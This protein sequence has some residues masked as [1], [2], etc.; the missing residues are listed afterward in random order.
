MDYI[1]GNRKEKEILKTRGD[2][3]TDLS[4]WFEITQNDAYEQI[5]DR[6]Y[7]KRKLESEIDDSGKYCV[8]YEITN[9]FR[10]V[11]KT[12]Y[13]FNELTTMKNEL[14]DALCEIDEANEERIAAIEDALCEMDM[15]GNE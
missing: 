14:E 6:C 7:I 13:L 5:T 2:E 1:F 12:D 4:G 10:Y 8:W 3:Y 11:D 15:G 9:H